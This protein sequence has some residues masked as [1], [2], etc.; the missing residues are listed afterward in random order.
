MCTDVQPAT[1]ARVAAQG[2]HPGTNL[3]LPPT[4]V[5][6][7]LCSPLGVELD[8]LGRSFADA[9]YLAELV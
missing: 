2:K 7:C 6:N 3:P 9:S 4:A 5:F 8:K 1:G